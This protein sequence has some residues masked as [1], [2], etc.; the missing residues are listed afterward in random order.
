MLHDAFLF[1]NRLGNY[2]FLPSQVQNLSLSAWEEGRLAVDRAC[3]SALAQGSIHLLPNRV[4]IV[5]HHPP[6]LLKEGN[7]VHK[8]LHNLLAGKCA[9]INLGWWTYEICFNSRIRQIHYKADGTILKQNSLGTLRAASFGHVFTREQIQMMGMQGDARP[10]VLQEYA[11][12]EACNTGTMTVL[13]KS[14]LRITCGFEYQNQLSSDRAHLV[15]VEPIIC[16]YVFTLFWGDMCGI[17]NILDDA[18][19]QEL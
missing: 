19:K 7:L 2:W 15:L 9:Y 16:E 4:Q 3:P 14:T 8:Q 11:E 12:G 5:Q 6:S 17:G 1:S 13:R 18:P 10:F